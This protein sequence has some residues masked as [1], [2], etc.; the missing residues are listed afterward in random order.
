MVVEEILVVDP[1]AIGG[2]AYKK[3]LADA[4]I[5]TANHRLLLQ[6]R[7]DPNKPGN[8]IVNLFGGHVEQGEKPIVAAARELHEETGGTPALDDLK[9]I[10]AVTESWTNHTEIVHVYFWHDWRNTITGCYEREGIEF[11]TVTEALSHPGLMSYAKWA[12]KECLNRGLLR[13]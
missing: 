4:V 5:L 2:Q 7:P 1:A 9:L 10:G 13:L 8:P 3:Q 12:L 11:A 6:K